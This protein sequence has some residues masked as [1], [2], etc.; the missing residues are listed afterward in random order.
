MKKILVILVGIVIVG[1]GIFSLVSAKGLSKRCTVEAVGT[2]T[3][4]KVE[5]SFEEDHDGVTRTS[6][7]YYPVIEYNAGDQIVSKQSN[8]GSGSPNYKVNDK[9]DILYNPDNVEEYIIKGDK[10]SN[11]VGIVFVAVGVVVAIFGFFKK[12]RH[13]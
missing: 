13:Y 6:Y 9:I 8:N 11:I 1:V 10:S 12:T 5:E 4:I 3:E 7:T 2:V